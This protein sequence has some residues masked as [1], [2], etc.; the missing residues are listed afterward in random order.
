MTKSL[1][2]TFHQVKTDSLEQKLEEA[3]RLLFEETIK[4]SKSSEIG[5]LS[6]LSSNKLSVEG[7][8]KDL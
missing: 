5:N 7:G 1:K 3:F 6:M 8:V 2:V 4:V